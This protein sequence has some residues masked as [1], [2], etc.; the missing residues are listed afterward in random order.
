VHDPRRPVEQ[1]D[2]TQFFWRALVRARSC[3]RRAAEVL[4]DDI[5]DVVAELP[6]PPEL[7]ARRGVSASRVWL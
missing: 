4:A 3:R 7:L 2:I 6:L 5:A 1:V